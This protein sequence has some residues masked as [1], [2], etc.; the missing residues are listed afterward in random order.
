MG[1]TSLIGLKD[2]RLAELLKPIMLVNRIVPKIRRV[3]EIKLEKVTRPVSIQEGDNQT[4][5]SKSSCARRHSLMLSLIETLMKNNL[6]SDKTRTAC[7]ASRDGLAGMD[8]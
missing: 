7:N 5:V 2:V 4:N 1:C 3:T 8:T 6:S